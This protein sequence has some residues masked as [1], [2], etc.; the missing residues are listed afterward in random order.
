[1][2]LNL[3]LWLF[4]FAFISFIVIFTLLKKEKIPVKYSLVWFV[5]SLTIFILAISPLSLSKVAKFIGFQTTSNLITGIMLVLLLFITMILTI[6]IST[7]NKKITLLI[8]EVSML[9]GSGKEND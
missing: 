9:K 8:Q 7:Q 4:L 2:S 6:I 3:R 1:M 5:S